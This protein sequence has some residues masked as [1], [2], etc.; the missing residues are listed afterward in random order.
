MQNIKLHDKS[1]EL[2]LAEKDIHLAIKELGKK[3]QADYKDLNPI[4][5]GV[6][7]GSFLFIADLIRQFEGNCEV[8][9]LRMSSYI[10]TK[11]SENIKTLIGLNENLKDRHVIIVEDIVDTGNTIENLF[12]LISKEEPAS[13]KVSTLLFKPDVYKKDIPIDY[14]AINV[15]NEFLVGYGLDYDGLGRNLKDIYVINS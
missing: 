8:S 3:I 14:V 6:L 1:F 9:F 12:E 4:F 15:G 13:L 2:F 11:S 10:G 5:I 7:N